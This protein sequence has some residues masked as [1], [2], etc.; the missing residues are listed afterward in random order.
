MHALSTD[1]PLLKHWSGVTV[2][3]T[4]SVHG[5]SFVITSWCEHFIWQSLTFFIANTLS[6]GG[7]GIGVASPSLHGRHK[8]L[9]SVSIH[10]QSADVLPMHVSLSIVG[11]P[12]HGE[13]AIESVSRS[14]RSWW[15]R[16]CRTSLLIMEASMED[17][18]KSLCLPAVAASTA[19]ADADSDSR[20]TTVPRKSNRAEKPLLHR[21]VLSRVV[22]LYLFFYRSMFTTFD[23]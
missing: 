13:S 7:Q 21:G 1:V 10:M 12:L 17:F 9:E 14:W 18:S 15:R 5:L 3:P 19:D 8:F 2:P 20:A 22:M 23:E 11:G 4:T 6:I 16:R